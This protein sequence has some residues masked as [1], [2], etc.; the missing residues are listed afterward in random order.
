WLPW[1]NLWRAV[2][3]ERQKLKRYRRLRILLDTDKHIR[4]YW[5]GETLELPDFY[6]QWVKRD[7]GPLMDY[8]PDGALYHDPNAYLAE[9]EAAGRAGRGSRR[10]VGIAV[11]SRRQGPRA[12]AVGRRPGGHRVQKPVHSGKRAAAASGL[13][14]A[15]RA[16]DGRGRC[17]PAALHRRVRSVHV[18]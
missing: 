10:R 14:R 17:S 11:L 18:P 6:L 15:R 16:L 2:S 8:L 13:F 9:T 12:M 7:L 5:E 3:S 4:R 1:M